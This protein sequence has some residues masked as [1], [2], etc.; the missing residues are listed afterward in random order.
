MPDVGLDTMRHIELACGVPSGVREH[1][2]AVE[3]SINHHCEA[4][5]VECTG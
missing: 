1:G 3:V 5:G 2:M 4:D